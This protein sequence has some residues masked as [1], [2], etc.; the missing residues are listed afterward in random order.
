MNKNLHV[1]GGQPGMGKVTPQ[2]Q[3]G[4]STKR[5]R[6]IYMIGYLEGREEQIKADLERKK[7][8]CRKPR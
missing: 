5:D 1:A 2:E 4:L 6:I 3:Y 7:K 8:K